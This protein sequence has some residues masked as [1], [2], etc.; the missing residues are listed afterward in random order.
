MNVGFLGRFPHINS[1]AKELEKI[2]VNVTIIPGKNKGMLHKYAESCDLIYYVNMSA[3]IK[4]ML[5][6]MV[7]LLNAKLR[8]HILVGA[9]GSWYIRYH[10]PLP[11]GVITRLYSAFSML[12]AMAYNL[13][14]DNIYAHFLNKFEQQFFQRI[15]KHKALVTR[16]L[17]NSQYYFMQHVIKKESICYRT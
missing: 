10:R 2:G 14:K 4:S 1:L 17:G 12:R 6:E 7:S 15:L 16:N 5:N 13:L 11:K 3:E 8:R 9:H